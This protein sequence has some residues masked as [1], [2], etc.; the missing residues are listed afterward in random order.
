MMGLDQNIRMSTTGNF[1]AESIIRKYKKT[2]EYAYQGISLVFLET[3]KEKEAAPVKSEVSILYHLLLQEIYYRYYNQMVINRNEIL[4][5]I[6]RAIEQHF[7]LAKKK[8]PQGFREVYSLYQEMK[9]LTKEEN[10]QRIE[11]QIQEK[12]GITIEKIDG[13]RENAERI[14]PMIGIGQDSEKVWTQVKTV[15]ENTK[16]VHKLETRKADSPKIEKRQQN[17][18]SSQIQKVSENNIGQ[19]VLPM[20]EK[21][22]KI[23]ALYGIQEKFFHQIERAKEITNLTGQEYELQQQI[24]LSLVQTATKEEQQTLYQ[25][26]DQNHFVYIDI[27]QINKNQSNTEVTETYETA[28]LLQIIRDMDIEYIR[29]LAD[30][31]KKEIE[32]KKENSTDNVLNIESITREIERTGETERKRETLYVVT[33]K[34]EEIE[35]RKREVTAKREEDRIDRILETENRIRKK[36][37]AEKESY[38]ISEKQRERTEHISMEYSDIVEQSLLYLEWKLKEIFGKEN[39]E[40]IKQEYLKSLSLVLGDETEDRRERE[41]IEDT[42]G[43][44]RKEIIIEEKKQQRNLEQEKIWQSTKNVGIDLKKET[45]KA[46][47]FSII[48]AESQLELSES[49]SEDFFLKNR[50]EETIRNMNESQIRNLVEKWKTE[51]DMIQNT[52]EENE[53]SEK[54]NI[55]DGE[56]EENQA[57]LIIQ[58]LTEIQRIK[59]NLLNVVEEGKS[60]DITFLYEY[61]TDR[62]LIH[63]HLPEKEEVRRNQEIKDRQEKIIQT[64]EEQHQIEKIDKIERKD[65]EKD[66]IERSE[67]DKSLIQKRRE[68]EDFLNHLKED[69][70]EELLVFWQKNRN[71]LSFYTDKDKTETEERKRETDSIVQRKEISNKLEQKV[72]SIENTNHLFLNTEKI[73]VIKE[74][75]LTSVE[76]GES[77]VIDSFYEYLTERNLIYR[78]HAEREE[79]QKEVKNYLKELQQGGNLQEE[80]LVSY[81]NTHFNAIY[82][83]KVQEERERLERTQVELGKVQEERVRLERTQTEQEKVQQEKTRSEELQLERAQVELGKVQEERVR[84]ERTQTEQEK[85]QQEKI[86]SEKV[87]SENTQIET[88]ITQGQVQQREKESNFALVSRDIRIHKEREQ[89]FTVQEKMPYV[90][91]LER[92]QREL[93]RLGMNGE[94]QQ[95]KRMGIFLRILEESSLEE[96]NS[97]YQYMEQNHLLY[98]EKNKILEQAKTEKSEAETEIEIR[99]TGR[100]QTQKGQREI[101][102]SLKKEILMEWIQSATEETFYKLQEKFI[103][104][105]EKQQMSFLGQV[106]LE[107]LEQQKSSHI[108]S[109]LTKYFESLQTILVQKEKGSILE[110]QKQLLVKT[111]L[112]GS[113]EEEQNLYDYLIENHFIYRKEEKKQ[114]TESEKERLSFEKKRILTEQIKQFNTKELNQLVEQV[115][116]RQKEQREMTERTEENS[117]LTN[118]AIIEQNKLIYS[119]RNIRIAGEKNMLIEHKLSESGRKYLAKENISILANRKVVENRTEGNMTSYLLPYQEV[120]LLL[121]KEQNSPEESKEQVKKVKEVIQHD[122]T[123]TTKEVERQIN[124]ESENTKKEMEKQQK[125]LLFIK[126]ELKQQQEKIEEMERNQLKEINSEKIYQTVMKKMEAQLR[127]ERLK[128]GLN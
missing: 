100:E 31:W 23:P 94:N 49:L 12:I 56:S 53:K 62:N 87:P 104:E 99:K 9:N 116:V 77:E 125:E 22:S 82:S 102:E 39:Y 70:E 50:L 109:V 97:L 106:S 112:E 96:S 37:M 40:T 92:Y 78:K 2:G 123:K 81:W 88:E 90:L 67:E 117:F 32:T 27:N 61:L 110:R 18:L 57:G 16:M 44:N 52:K 15:Q 33:E 17:M 28:E 4:T 6:E 72:Q 93:Q 119:G 124:W 48:S 24:L 1:F 64:A 108:G 34:Q 126:T 20:Q 58:P 29:V 65:L 68:I 30:K 114:Q 91:I 7:D 76:T 26:F 11:K 42:R 10:L 118:I 43:E 86:W 60:E 79:K 113:K 25:Y 69:T 55:R 51:T 71:K 84:L 122:M 73:G 3:A 59:K 103:E 47:L 98:Y 8:E 36:E 115:L 111:I 95:E 121:K 21:L 85:V 35:K 120:S 105:Y 54:R 127:L 38:V 14:Q 83:K 41:K 101:E 63:R 75:L 107:N 5:G 80:L 46:V 13:V 19:F 74:H 128:R 45:E 66:I 89:R